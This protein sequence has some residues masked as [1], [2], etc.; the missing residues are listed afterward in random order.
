M[1]YTCFF[2][3]VYVHVGKMR[4]IFLGFFWYFCRESNSFYWILILAKTITAIV[5]CVLLLENISLCWF[6]GS[7]IYTSNSS[8]CILYCCSTYETST[9]LCVS[10]LPRCWCVGY[11][12]QL[13]APLIHHCSTAVQLMKP[14]PLLCVS[15][16][17]RCWCVGYNIQLIAP[18]IHHCSTAVQLMKPPPLLCV[19]DLPRCWCVGYNIQL[20]APL[21][22]H[23]STAVQLMKPLPLLCVSDLPR[24]WPSRR[25]DSD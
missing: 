3:H 10:D 2:I 21:I 23:C 14:P 20:F 25:R 15:D 4:P 18:L 5:L 22:H 13:I 8:C 17:P 7:I 11:N 16:L 19:S 1:L 24:R 12:I 6:S 9:L